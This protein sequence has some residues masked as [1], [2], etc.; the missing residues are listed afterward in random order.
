MAG[1]QIGRS[2]IG[3]G[4]FA[5]EEVEV[6][7]QGE[8]ED[9]KKGRTSLST[10]QLEKKGVPRT[11]ARYG[12]GWVNRK[13]KHGSS[14]VYTCRRLERFAVPLS[15]IIIIITTRKKERKN[16]PNPTCH[17]HMANYTAIPASQALSAK[18]KFVS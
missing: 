10:C 1:R 8:G 13:C 7:G 14:F 6:E 12:A 17:G 5:H 18:K 4:L 9:K 2:R 15:I 16:I 11:F 3:G